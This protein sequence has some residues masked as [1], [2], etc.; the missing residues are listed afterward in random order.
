MNLPISAIASALVAAFMN[1]KRPSGT[2]R[3]KFAKVDWMYALSISTF[4]AYEI[5]DGLC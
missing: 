4:F 2:F 1:V 3:E 5:T